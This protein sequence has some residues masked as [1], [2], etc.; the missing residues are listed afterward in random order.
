MHLE[1]LQDADHRATLSLPQTL[2]RV[3]PL[4]ERWAVPSSTTSPRKIE[5]VQVVYRQSGDRYL[6]VE[7][8]PLVLD[9]NL[10]FRVH[11]LMQWV[12]QAMDAGSLQGILDLTPGIRSLQIHFDCRVLSREDIGEAYSS[13]Q[14]R[15]CHAIEDM[16]VP[17]RIVHLPL[18]WDDPATRLA[19]EKYM[20]SVR[21]D[22]PWCPS[23]IEFIRRINGLDRHRDR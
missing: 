21:K 9:L 15:S 14:R 8:G 16:E 1:R 20:Q 7:Y 2:R 13:K 12:Q 11:A 5:Q 6:L 4:Q 3:F 17:T 10:R 22:A 23:N 18:S 19:I